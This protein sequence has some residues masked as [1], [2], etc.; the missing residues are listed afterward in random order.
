MRASDLSAQYL[1]DEDGKW[2]R[3]DGGRWSGFLDWLSNQVRCCCLGA[4]RLLRHLTRCGCCPD[5]QS[6]LWLPGPRVTGSVVCTD[7]LP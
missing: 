7:F 6:P 5:C 3:M 1:R 2:G 4:C